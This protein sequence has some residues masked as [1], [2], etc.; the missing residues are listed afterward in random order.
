MPR[1]AKRITRKTKTVPYDV[2]EQSRTPEEM[3]AYV[4]S[5]TSRA[6]KVWRGWLATPASAARVSTRLSARTV[7]R[8][9][10]RSSRWPRPSAFG[11]MQRLRRD[12]AEPV[13]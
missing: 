11:C 2:A 9:S 3:A 7:T 5:A 6:R 1:T 13:A 4:R 10:R 12:A 8:A